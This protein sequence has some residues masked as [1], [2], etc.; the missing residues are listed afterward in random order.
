MSWQP[1]NIMTLKREFVQFALQEGAR[2]SALCRRYEISRKTGYKWIKRYREQGEA[3][4]AERSRRPGR[5]PGQTGGKVAQSITALR[6]EHPAW[7]ARKLR[8]V[9]QREGHKRVPCVSTVHA[10]LRRDGLISAEASGKARAWQRF[11]RETPNELWQMDFKGHFGVGTRGARCH[12]LTVLDDCSRFNLVLEACA[13]ET[14]AVVQEHLSGCFRRYGLP[15]AILCDNGSPWGC[16]SPGPRR[17]TGLEVWLM[18]A[19]VR[20]LARAAVS[21][22][23]PGQGG[24]LSPHF[25][26]GGAGEKRAVAGFGRGAAGL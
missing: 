15:L 12:A 5:S 3:G 26:G 9:L 19:G 20:V 10:V 23:N 17:W 22:A 7:G 1:T 16:A 21:S 25:G 4:L 2:I 11:A 8:A 18:R 13:R 24:A 14:R 6:R